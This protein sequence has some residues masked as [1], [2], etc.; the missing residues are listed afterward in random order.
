[1]SSHAESRHV[2]Y[3]A[4]L[5][6]EVV[7]D[8]EQYPSFLPWCTALRILSR[9]KT[10]GK[11]IIFA[12]MAVAYSALREKYTSRVTLDPQTHSI[13]VVQTE[14][15]FRQLEN[16]WRFTPDGEGCQIDFLITFEF[17]SRILNAVVGNS[18]EKVFMKMADAFEARAK[19]LSEQAL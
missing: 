6:Y 14:G 12:Q 3:S 5:M 13:D 9:E 7:S 17:K 1:M 2:P 18:F 11:E 19:T 10:D 15:P 16:R 8:V 4:D